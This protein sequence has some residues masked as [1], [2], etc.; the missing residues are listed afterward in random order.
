MSLE[1]KVLPERSKVRQKTC[2]RSG[3]R[4]LRI[5][6]SRLRVG[7]WPFSAWLFTR[8]GFDERVFDVCQFGDFCLRHRMA[9]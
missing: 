7:W 5:R 6:R 9:A 8:A 1:R 4:N 3:T 2:V